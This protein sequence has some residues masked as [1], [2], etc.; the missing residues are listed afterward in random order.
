MD[1]NKNLKVNEDEFV[2][3]CMQD[4]ELCSLLEQSLG[5]EAMCNDSNAEVCK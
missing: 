4:D 1:K 3:A 2:E 5:K